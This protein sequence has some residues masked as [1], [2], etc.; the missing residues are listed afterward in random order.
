MNPSIAMITMHAQ[1]IA[2]HSLMD[3]TT[4]RKSVLIIA[5]A[6]LILATLLLANASLPRLIAMITTLA[7][8]THATL[9]AVAKTHP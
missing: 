2:A 8:L 7:P 1:L 9:P 4:Y 5:H 3:V 6:Q